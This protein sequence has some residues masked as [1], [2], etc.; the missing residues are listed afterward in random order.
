MYRA[1]VIYYYIAL[2]ASG[3]PSLYR[4]RLGNIVGPSEELV[5][6]IENLQ[7]RYGL[8]RSADVNQ[9]TGYIETEG[10][11]TAINADMSNWRRVGQ[12][13]V[14]LQVASPNPATSLQAQAENQSWMLDANQTAPDDRR[15]RQV[16]Q[17]TIALRNRLY[18]N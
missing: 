12:V 2:G 3:L 1:E 9:P 8:D 18:G 7:F 6:G 11:A 14:A 15:F 13:Q 4:A 10:N 17:S 16:Y 5:E